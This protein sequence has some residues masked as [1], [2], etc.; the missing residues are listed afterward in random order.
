MV[1]R[2]G[3]RTVRGADGCCSEGHFDSREHLSGKAQ[4]G[5]DGLRPKQRCIG[6]AQECAVL[7]RIRPDELAIARQT[8][9]RLD[10]DKLGFGPL[11]GAARPVER[12]SCTKS[13]VVAM[14]VI[15]SAVLFSAPAHKTVIWTL[16]FRIST[17]GRISILFRILGEMKGSVGMNRLPILKASSALIYRSRRSCPE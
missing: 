7:E 11:D 4:I 17:R 13:G 2:Y 14:D 1:G 5:T 9:L 16:P 12:R 3:C 6:L 15:V 8:A 10:L